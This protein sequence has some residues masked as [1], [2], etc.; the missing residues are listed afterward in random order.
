MPIEPHKQTVM[1][2]S[3]PLQKFSTLVRSI[4][5]ADAPH[6]YHDNSP[7]LRACLT[8][9][10][11]SV[12]FADNPVAQKDRAAGKIDQ[13]ISCCMALTGIME[14]I[15]EPRSVYDSSSVI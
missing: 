8:N 14:Q 3:P 5:R 12:D 10:R 13:F 1:M 2:M 7:V 15:R 4:N 11:V 9:V 6:I